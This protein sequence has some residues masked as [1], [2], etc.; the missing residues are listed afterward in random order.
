M[1]VGEKK[2]KISYVTQRKKMNM[3]VVKG[4]CPNLL[5]RKWLRPAQ[6]DWESIEITCLA[7]SQIQSKVYSLLQKYPEVFKEGT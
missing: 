4:D 3:F 7:Q 6:L 1:L 5:G 2:V